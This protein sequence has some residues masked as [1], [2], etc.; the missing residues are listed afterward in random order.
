MDL[1]HKSGPLN[2]AGDMGDTGD[3]M[4]LSSGGAMVLGGS[5][6]VLLGWAAK[7]RGGQAHTIVPSVLLPEVACVTE[8]DSRN[9]DVLYVSSNSVPCV[10][11]VPLGSHEEIIS[12]CLGNV[13]HALV[14]KLTELLLKYVRLFPNLRVLEGDALHDA[15]ATLL[16]IARQVNA[17]VPELNW[18]KVWDCCPDPILTNGHQDKGPSVASSS[19]SSDQWAGLI[20]PT[21]C[22]YPKREH[23]CP[24]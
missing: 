13:N 1:I 21:I 2:I 15:N 8:G 16:Q 22:E 20:E 12:E 18:L 9:A 4:P 5:V 23:I 19:D 10:P 3:S 24:F 7:T 14:P 11:P 6:S 17:F